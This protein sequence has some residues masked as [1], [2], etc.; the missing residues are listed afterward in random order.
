M[1]FYD[2][3]LI[4]GCA[5]IQIPDAIISVYLYLKR[6][7]YNKKCQNKLLIASR[8]VQYDHLF[9]SDNSQED[10]GNFK[11]AVKDNTKST[12]DAKQEVVVIEI[13]EMGYT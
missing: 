5:V 13:E 12:S 7:V 11:P 1:I 2:L 4:L 3:T 10:E 8:H 6:M 9:C